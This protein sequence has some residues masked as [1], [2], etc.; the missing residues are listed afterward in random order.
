MARPGFGQHFFIFAGPA[1]ERLGF[2]QNK[3]FL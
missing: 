3:G 2:L 1:Q